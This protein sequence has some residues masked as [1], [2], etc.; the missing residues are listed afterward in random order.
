MSRAIR[1]TPMSKVATPPKYPKDTRISHEG[2]DADTT[3]ILQMLS[4][5]RNH[6]S[7]GEQLFIERFITPPNPTVI[8][9]LAF[10]IQT[11][12]TE[13][14]P[15]LFSCHTDTVHRA[16]HGVRQPVEY[17]PNLCLA[18]SGNAQPL[19]ADDGAGCWLL[20]EMIKAGVKG[21][22]VFHRAEEK[23]GI[24]SSH[25]ADHRKAFLSDYK[26]AVAFD[27]RGQG[28]VITH[29]SSGRCASDEFAQA[30]ADALMGA[31]DKL[32]YMPSDDGIFTDTANYTHL[33]PECTNVSCGY[34]SEH[35][36]DESLNIEH[37]IAL[38]DALVKVDWAALPIKRDVSDTG[39]LWGYDIDKDSANYTINDLVRMTKYEMAQFAW[40]TPSAFANLVYELINEQ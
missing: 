2:L 28:D 27:R 12:P 22:F 11:A 32:M 3:A 1:K 37:L 5:V 23:G 17:D 7:A 30:L 38:R 19:G 4:Y 29:Q 21:T 8:D 18:F 25:M 34:E 36:A 26:M 9:D 35:T 14:A 33:I 24:G 16:E 40:S 6:D 10:V 15:F 13:E 31:N 20:L 39:D